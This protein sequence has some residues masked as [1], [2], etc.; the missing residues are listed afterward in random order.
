MTVKEFWTVTDQSLFDS[1]AFERE[2]RVIETAFFDEEGS[3]RAIKKFFGCEVERVKFN[4]ELR[5][6][7]IVIG[8]QG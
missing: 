7:I 3:F 8:K 4:L 5:Q 6:I 2:N 1:M